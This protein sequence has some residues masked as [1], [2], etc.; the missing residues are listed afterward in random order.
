[1]MVLITYDISTEDAGG[2]RRLRHVAKICQDYGI[3]VQYSIFECEV[4]PA[5]WVVLRDRLLS[6]Y[7]E[8]SDS[9]RF[10]QLGA[11]WKKRVEHQGAKASFD[12]FRD[13]LLV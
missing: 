8:D 10:Y 1:M 2:A 4:T 7:D 11:N 5:Q 12:M 6:A 9:L 13:T 3:R